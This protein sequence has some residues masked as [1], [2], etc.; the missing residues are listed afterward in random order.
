M[1]KLQDLKGAKALSKKERQKINGGGHP[2]CHANIH[3]SQC[4]DEDPGTVFYVYYVNGVPQD[5]GDCCVF[6]T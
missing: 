4:H 2:G 3:Y 1:K 6:P 5:Y